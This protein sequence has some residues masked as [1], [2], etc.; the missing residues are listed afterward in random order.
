MSD[1]AYN[2]LERSREPWARRGKPLRET[3]RRG[4]LFIAGAYLAAAA[5]LALLD[6]VGRFSV[7]TAVLYCVGLAIAMNVRFDVGAGYT[8]ATQAVFVPML[9]ALPVGLI[10]LLMPLALALGMAPRV[11]RG[12]I[13]PSWLVM[14]VGNGWFAIGPAIVLSIVSPARALHHDW[15]VLLLAL[16]AQLAFDFLGSAAR[17]RLYQVQRVRRLLAELVPTWAV[18]FTLSALGLAIAYAAGPLRSQLALLLVAPLFVILRFFS[19]ER[20]ERLRQLAELNDAYQGTAL[21]LGDVVEADDSYTGAHSKSVVRIA[22]AVAEELRLDAQRKRNVELGALLHDVGKI[23][24][25]KEIINKRGKL[26]EREWAIIRMHTIEG[27][28]MLERIGGLMLD[29]GRIVRASHERWDGT[30]YP[31][32]LS[33][34]DIPLE[35]RIIA[36]CDAFNAMTTTR[37][38]RGAMD[39]ALARE[40][41]ARCAG[42]QFDPGVVAA[43][44]T[45]LSPKLAPESLAAT[46]EPHPAGV[47]A[48][49]VGVAHPLAQ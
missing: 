15:P 1:R 33:R 41:L 25:P 17:E 23:A 48:T 5:G 9:F 14:A 37:S 39:E 20:Q 49:I 12:E 4:E 19:N 38:Y 3:V 6:G 31:D 22:L 43:L 46:I 21:L 26:D 45:V 10:A 16:A 36:T 44:L 7:A 13:T 11:L 42:S 34:E 32:G 47:W 2:E 24:V 40:E 18:D 35:A 8:V 29:I 30:G 27:Q 28:R